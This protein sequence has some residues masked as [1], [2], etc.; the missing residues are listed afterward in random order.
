MSCGDK[1]DSSTQVSICHERVDAC[2][3]VLPF[4]ALNANASRER[5]PMTLPGTRKPPG[6]TAEGLGMHRAKLRG[7]AIAGR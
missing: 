7:G 1:M 3:Y 5:A 6:V 4:Q 2:G